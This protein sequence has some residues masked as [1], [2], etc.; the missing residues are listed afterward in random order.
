R[1]GHEVGTPVG[2]PGAPQGATVLAAAAAG[3]TLALAD[4]DALGAAAGDVLRVDEGPAEEYARVLRASGATVTVAPALALL[5]A[6]GRPVARLAAS[7]SGAAFL[8]WLAGWVG[9]ALRPGRGERW[10]RE[11]LR[12]AGRIAPWRGTRAGVEAFLNAS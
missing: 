9:L 1:F 8:E 2:V 3:D 5:H 4:P 7:G 12:V 11:L 10:N 6:A